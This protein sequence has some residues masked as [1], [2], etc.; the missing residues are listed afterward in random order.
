VYWS[1]QYFEEELTW[2]KLV[3]SD[4]LA[5]YRFYWLNAGYY[6]LAGSPSR[7]TAG[8]YSTSNISET[9]Q[10]RHVVTRNLLGALVVTLWTCYGAL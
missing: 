2:Q 1:L 6:S 10:D 3:G 8:Y 4:E 9:I 5:L 7:V